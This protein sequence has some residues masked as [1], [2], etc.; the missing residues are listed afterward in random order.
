MTTFPLS[1]QSCRIR[2]SESTSS[3]MLSSS[4]KQMTVSKEPGGMASPGK[5][6]NQPRT[7]RMFVHW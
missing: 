5:S 4:R 6:D 1:R 7:N 2:L 3:P